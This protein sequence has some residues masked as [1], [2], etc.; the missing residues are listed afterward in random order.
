M[1]T[2]LRR[3]L[4]IRALLCVGGLRIIFKIHKELPRVSNLSA[5]RESLK[6]EYEMEIWPGSLVAMDNGPAASLSEKNKNGSS[7]C[8]YPLP[9]VPLQNFQRNKAVKIASI[10][11]QKVL[12][13]CLGKPWSFVSESFIARGFTS[14]RL[15]FLFPYKT[16]QIRRFIDS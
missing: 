11:F 12:V 14:H 4:V 2:S 1:S 7:S 8:G 10:I 3:R 15:S 16:N 6:S 5:Q 13:G 9:A